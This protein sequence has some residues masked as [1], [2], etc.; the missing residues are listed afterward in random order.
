MAMSARRRA[1]E[2]FRHW[3]R[4]SD[5]EVITN[6]PKTLCNVA[7]VASS[8]PQASI[9]ILTWTLVDEVLTCWPPGPP[10]RTKLK[11]TAD[12][13]TLL[14]R[15]VEY[16]LTLFMLTDRTSIH[17]SSLFVAKVVG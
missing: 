11:R 5:D 7:A 9:S 16:E 1:S 12:S 3:E 14:P 17:W 6:V 13:G 4:L 10:E 2:R 15:G 8:K